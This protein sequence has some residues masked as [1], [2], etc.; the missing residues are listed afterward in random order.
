MSTDNI[1]EAYSYNQTNAQ[2]ANDD[3]NE[4]VNK[5]SY[6]T[7]LLLNLFI[8]LWFILGNYWI[9]SIYKPKF[10]P[11]IYEPNN[12]CDRN[13][14]FFSLLQLGVYYSL[15]ILVSLLVFL[16]TIFTQIPYLITKFQE[17]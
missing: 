11:F 6:F 2:Q 1:S 7:D 12:F 16:L 14:Y 9:F 17:F 4:S 15:I 3:L 13:L 10:K 5:G 8:F